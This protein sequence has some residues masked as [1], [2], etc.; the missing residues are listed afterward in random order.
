M[1]A[2]AIICSQYE[3]GSLTLAHD[4]YSKGTIGKVPCLYKGKPLTVQFPELYAQ[5]QGIQQMT[6]AET[7]APMNPNKVTLSL[8]LAGLDSRKSVKD[9]MSMLEDMDKV[10]IQEGVKNSAKWFGK[11]KSEAII[12]E[13]LK[14]KVK[15]S[16]V[17]DSQG[18]RTGEIN[19]NYPPSLSFNLYKNDGKI[20]IETVDGKDR[21][22]DINSIDLKDSLVTVIAQLNSIWIGNSMFGY[23]WYVKKIR[24][25]PATKKKNILTFLDDMDRIGTTDNEGDELDETDNENDTKRKGHIPLHDVPLEDSDADVDE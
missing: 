13:F 19:T 7:G 4:K 3:P 9:C 5:G 16:I 8:S 12:D 14:R 22:I 23:T 24:V 6:D 10:A 2:S 11:L 17:K 1:S 18:N 15:Y 25:I 21:D 20:T